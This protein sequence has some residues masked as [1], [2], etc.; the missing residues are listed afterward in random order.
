MKKTLCLLAAMVALQAQAHDDSQ[1]QQTDHANH[2][3]AH[4]HGE[5]N[6]NIA[7]ENN[8]LVLMLKSPAVNIIGFEHEPGTEEQKAQSEKA[9]AMLKAT[10]KWLS[11]K[12]GNCHLHAAD[13][14]WG[15]NSH[16]NHKEAEYEHAHHDGGESKDEHSEHQDGEHHHGA[17]S[18]VRA[19][20]AFE[21]KKA[22][23]L[24]SLKIAFFDKFPQMEKVHIQWIVGDKQ[25]SQT[26]TGEANELP[27]D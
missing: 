2:I 21:C 9:L 7:L 13:I 8:E 27:L 19:T 10:D 16:H 4:V 5:A 12:G 25:G 15:K 1:P 24:E 18:D 22:T 26:L 23:E 20:F 3:G 14:D 17:H 6:L 11:I